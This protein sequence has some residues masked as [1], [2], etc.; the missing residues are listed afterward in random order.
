MLSTILNGLLNESLKSA[1]ND[2][3]GQAF[4]FTLLD[5]QKEWVIFYDGTKFYPLPPESEYAV[6]LRANL[7]GLSALMRKEKNVPD[8]K[9][10]IEGDLQLAQT[11]QS[12]FQNL[13]PDAQTFLVEKLGTVVGGGIYQ[14][15][16]FGQAQVEALEKRF[17]VERDEFDDF[18]H[19]LQH[20][21]QR[22]N[23]LE[24]K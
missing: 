19:Q 23:Q 11:L 18:K 13:K 1:L 10:H 8:A 4:K 5:Y 14:A 3:S 17:F 16:Q 6:A 20:L 7:I 24:Q 22:L 21:I 9:L 15:V 12:A 2:F